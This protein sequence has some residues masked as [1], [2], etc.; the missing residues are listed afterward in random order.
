ME[1]VDRRP[2]GKIQLQLHPTSVKRHV[3]KFDLP[4]SHSI[5]ARA[6]VG[7]FV[8]FLQSFEE[9]ARNSRAHLRSNNLS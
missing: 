3:T 8:E 5:P 2:Q 7:A 9:T 1:K 4:R 6:R